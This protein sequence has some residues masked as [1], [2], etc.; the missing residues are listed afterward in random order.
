MS[1]SLFLISAV[2][3]VCTSEKVPKPEKLGS[4]LL[5]PSESWVE[6]GTQ[7]TSGLRRQKQEASWSWL[8]NQ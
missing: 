7:V 6:R 5:H 1:E 3:S 8:T 4:D 2:C